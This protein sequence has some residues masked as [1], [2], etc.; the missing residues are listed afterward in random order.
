VR[1]AGSL[2]YSSTEHTSVKE[3][4][5]RA[6]RL[7]SNGASLFIQIR[8]VLAVDIEVLREYVPEVPLRY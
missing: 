2:D 6:K 3:K 7:G 4:D 8:K 5:E 1:R